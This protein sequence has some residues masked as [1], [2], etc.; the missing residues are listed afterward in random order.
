MMCPRSREDDLRALV[1]AWESETGFE[2]EWARYRSLH[3]ASVNTYLAI[4][5]DGKLKRKGLLADPWAE[6]DLRGQMS[7]NPQ[8][9]ILGEA[10]LELIRDETPIAETVG[11][12]VDPRKFVTVINVRG[13]GQWRGHRLGRVAR[14]Y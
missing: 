10:V 4:K 1:R 12:C 2:V 8:M 14:Y 13:G 3:S 11:S 6:G 9:T 7:K 5:E